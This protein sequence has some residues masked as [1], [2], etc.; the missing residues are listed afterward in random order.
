MFLRETT[1]LL[2]TAALSIPFAMQDGAGTAPAAD[3]S[4]PAA[5]VDSG[6]ALSSRVGAVETKVRDLETI[7][8]RYLV[9]PATGGDPAALAA[10][11]TGYATLI[12]RVQPH[13]RGTAEV[14]VNGLPVAR[15]DEDKTLDLGPFLK[16]AK[17]NAIGFHF[18]ARDAANSGDMEAEIKAVPPGT[19]V[20]DALAIYAFTTG[21]NKLADGLLVPIQ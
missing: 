10:A 4:A 8:D 5:N 20:K 18:T 9:R 17:V 16:R 14:R 15:Y 19:N 11:D 6:A 12:V 1:A 2:V 13:G 7:V 3:K 21:A